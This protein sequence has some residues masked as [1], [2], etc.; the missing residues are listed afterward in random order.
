[1]K[2][3]DAVELA[4]LVDLFALVQQCW[5]GATSGTTAKDVIPG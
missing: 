1:M 3:D 2:N 4:R 5:N